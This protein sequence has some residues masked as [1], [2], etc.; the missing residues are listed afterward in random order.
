MLNQLIFL[1]AWAVRVAE[2]GMNSEPRLTLTADLDLASFAYISQSYFQLRVWAKMQGASD[3]HALFTLELW[4]LNIST[5][6]YIDFA[7]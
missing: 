5:L 1:E 6:R 3:S 2:S 7:S 4:A